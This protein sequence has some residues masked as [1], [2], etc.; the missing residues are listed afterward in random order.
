[1]L[2]RP[3]PAAYSLLDT[4]IFASLPLNSSASLVS[5][6]VHLISMEI[7]SS[8]YTTSRHQ[9]YQLWHSKTQATPYTFSFFPRLFSRDGPFSPMQRHGGRKTELSSMPQGKSH[10]MVSIGST[11]KCKLEV[12]CGISRNKARWSACKPRTKTHRLVPCLNS[13]SLH[14]AAHCSACPLE[15]LSHRSFWTGAVPS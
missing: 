12:S 10:I 7:I 8:H 14:S 2:T 15:R 9:A 6:R 4:M 3:E 1:M 5:L 13:K 11:S